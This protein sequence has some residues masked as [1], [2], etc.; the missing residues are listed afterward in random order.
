MDALPTGTVTMVFTDIEGSTA[1]LSRLGDRYAQALSAHRVLLRAAWGRWAG[2]EMGTEGDSFFVVFESAAHA[3]RACLDGQRALCSFEWPEGIVLRVRMGIHTGELARHEDSYVGMDVHRAARIAA[4]AHGGQVVLSEGTRQLVTTGRPDGVEIRD[5]GWHRLKDLPAP[6]RI[7]QLVAPG[8]LSDLP[9]I[10]SMGAPTNLPLPPTPLVG[11]EEELAQVHDR[12]LLPDVRLVTLTGAGGSG[13]TRLA[14]AVAASLDQHF[15]S[16][17]FFVPL[18]AATDA[19]M[20]WLAIAEAVGA[21]GDGPASA[22]VSDHLRER[23]ALLVLD[24][25]EHLPEAPGVV[26]ALLN[27]APHLS[28]LA[29]SRR[30]LHLQGE[31]EHPV[32]PLTLPR[33]TS[34]ALSEVASA[35]AV[36]LFV[37]QAGM[38]RPNFALTDATAADVAAICTR[39]DGLPLAIELAASRVK[40]LT[41]RALLGRLD[42]R[43]TLTAGDTGRPARQQTLRDTIAWSYDLLSVDLQR[44]FRRTGVFVGGAE[45]DAVAA[46]ASAEGSSPG[47]P[48]PLEAVAE[49]VDFSLVTIGE[50]VDG[51]PRVGMLQTIREFALERLAAEDDPDA[52]RR[53]HAEYYLGFAERAAAELHGT[54]QLLWL[55]RLEAD[56]DNLRAALSWSLEPQQ[57]APGSDDRVSIGIRLVNALSWFWYGHCHAA[58]GRRWL[59]RAMEVAGDDGPDLARAVH[60]LGVLLLQQG[61]IEAGRGAL[62]RSLALWRHLGDRERVAVELSSLGVAHRMLSDIDTARALLQESVDVSRELRSDARLTTALSNL[63]IVEIDAGQPERAMVLLREALVIDRKRDDSWGVAVVEGNIAGALMQAGRLAEARDLLCSMIYNVVG[64]RD[65][66][67]LADTLERFA[68]LAAEL[69]DDVRA[70]RL[71]GAGEGIREKAGMPIS[72]PDAALLERSLVKARARLGPPAWQRE[73]SIGRK[74]ADEE[75]VAL[76]VQLSGESDV[77]TDGDPDLVRG[78]DRASKLS[79]PVYR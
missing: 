42:Q 45:L 11:R 1:L 79:P 37:Q 65:L 68:A 64:L 50:S 22:L 71:A 4:T 18:A 32:P 38:V 73:W 12:L 53:R 5:L 6:E 70:A 58:D 23:R 76:A 3:V 33:A 74:L 26:T 69:N 72:A 43:L 16:G 60:G 30:S 9:P 48:D 39:L 40:L 51:E 56:H 52:V 67:L 57:P 24:N 46:V 15:A 62:E 8:L 7:Y 44:L 29:T 28:V 2:R 59:E 25:L 17:V 61:E 31:H 55:D 20:M 27:A 49:L 41:P 78:A 63:A 47:E 14:V 75:A 21:T 35:G 13:K 77:R 34:G 10:R 36:K 66:E 54:Q 19:E